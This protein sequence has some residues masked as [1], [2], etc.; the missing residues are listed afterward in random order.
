MDGTSLSETDIRESLIAMIM[1][2]VGVNR[3]EVINCEDIERD[4]GCTGDDFFEL[5][6][7]YAKEFKVDMTGFLW[8][9]HSHEEGNSIGG[10]FFPS[11]DQR[12]ERIP[13]SLNTLTRSALAGK[14]S[15]QYPDHH[16]PKR[17]WDIRI[18]A[19]LVTLVLIWATMA[20]FR[21]C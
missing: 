12:V 18:N 8:Y 17:R 20:L 1:G 2:K 16:V 3:D 9:F 13:V 10:W 5:I 6:E 15:V 19:M 11:P 14:W 4:L 21:K 7:T